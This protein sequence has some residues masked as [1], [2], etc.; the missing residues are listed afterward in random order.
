MK[1]PLRWI[2]VS[3]LGS[4]F[5]ARDGG[6]WVCCLF[7]LLSLNYQHET[8]CLLPKKGKHERGP[9]HPL[10]TPLVVAKVFHWRLPQNLNRLLDHNDYIFL[11]LQTSCWYII[12][13]YVKSFFHAQFG[14]LGAVLCFNFHLIV[15]MFHWMLKRGSLAAT[16]FNCCPGHMTR[17]WVRLGTETDLNKNKIIWPG[18]PDP[19]SLFWIPGKWFRSK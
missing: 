13:L 16:I 11:S 12:F 18:H 10:A 5:T 17:S 15:S 14:M 4:A 8:C 19:L 6:L 3:G 9:P 7:Q 2:V 1:L